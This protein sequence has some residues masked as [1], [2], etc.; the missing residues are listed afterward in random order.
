MGLQ[1]GP[2]GPAQGSTRPAKPH[3]HHRHV[4]TT[5]TCRAPSMAS[6]GREVLHVADVS[7]PRPTRADIAWTVEVPRSAASELESEPV[8]PR[9]EAAAAK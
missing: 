3:T 9:D 5:R 8:S 7:T 4:T 2:P 6:W 1:L